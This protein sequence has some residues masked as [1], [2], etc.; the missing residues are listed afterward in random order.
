MRSRWLA[1][2]LLVAAVSAACD[3]GPVTNQPSNPS[4]IVPVIVVSG[5]SPVGIGSSSQFIAVVSGITPGTV[6]WSTPQG[7]IAS[8]S[9]TGVVTCLTPGVATII[10]TSTVTNVIQGS[11][12]VTCQSVLQV[13]VTALSFTHT[14]GSSPCPQAIGT[15]RVTNLAS[16]AITVVLAGHS[17]LNVD[18]GTASFAIAAGAFRDI[19]V[20][21]NCSTQTSFVGNMTITGTAGSAL[22]VKTVA[23]TGTINR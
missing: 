23:V 11:A 2:I 14:V 8:V 21:F 4:L 19:A 10:A 3:P 15:V 16:Q 7:A 5:S 20:S 22:E 6:T 17:A 13:S 9:A 18:T 12:T 1:V